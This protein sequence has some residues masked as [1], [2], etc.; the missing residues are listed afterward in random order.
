M[1]WQLEATLRKKRIPTKNICPMCD[2]TEETIVHL[3]LLCQWTTPIWFR[4]QICSV[5][6]EHSVAH[7]SEWIEQ[8]VD[9]MNPPEQGFEVGHCCVCSLVHLEVLKSKDSLGEKTKPF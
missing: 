4:L 2:E 9:P 5:P 8:F 3:F 1:L 7:I 6:N